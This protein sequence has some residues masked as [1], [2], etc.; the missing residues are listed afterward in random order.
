MEDSCEENDFKAPDKNMANLHKNEIGKNMQISKMSNIED[1]RERNEDT[2]LSYNCK[3]R[4]IEISSNFCERRENQVDSSG[5]NSVEK[6][7]VAIVKAQCITDNTADY[8]EKITE[9]LKC[10][11]D[12]VN[13]RDRSV[14]KGNSNKAMNVVN[15]GQCLRTGANER[16]RSVVKNCGPG[17]N[18]IKV[19][20]AGECQGIDE[21][22]SVVKD[23]CRGNKIMKI[24]D[25][26]Q[27]EKI[28]DVSG[29]GQG[30]DGNDNIMKE[31]GQGH[32]D[33]FTNTVHASEH[34]DRRKV[35]VFKVGK[36]RNQTNAAEI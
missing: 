2:A 25:T 27:C 18:D 8:A 19:M 23:E 33:A 5:V 24:M 4:K 22:R 28:V 30:H 31:E 14:M 3:N 17:G 32:E 11:A 26:G 13:V 15:T 7:K 35:E 10:R 29:N 12:D 36:I 6:C 16:D 20:D 34:I 1:M 9:T 21:N